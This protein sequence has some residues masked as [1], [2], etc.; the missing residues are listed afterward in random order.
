MKKMLLI[1]LVLVAALALS[2]SAFAVIANS[3]HDLTVDFTTS[4]SACEFC[5]TPHNARASV[6]TADRTPLWNRTMPA[7][8]FTMYGA[9]VSGTSI[10]TAGIS[11]PT[12][13]TT[14]G[15]NT[16]TC[17]SCHDGATALGAL[18]NKA[19]GTSNASTTTLVGL[20]GGT[21][22][23]IGTDLSDDHPVGFTFIDNRA[24]VTRSVFAT[25]GGSDSAG[26]GFRL[27]G[28]GGGTF[29]CASCHDP[30]DTASGQTTGGVDVGNGISGSR[31]SNYFLRANWD[32]ICTDCHA[33]K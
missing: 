7:G 19:D 12:P 15:A 29:Q 2:T 26:A 1:A 14:L 28:G 25:H 9:T 27:Y 13:N 31:P 17:L 10:G 8:P 3:L 32:T 11:G 33:N 22:T 5:H 16:L 24:G 23:T 6:G 20:T 21:A 18:L 30:H 4:I